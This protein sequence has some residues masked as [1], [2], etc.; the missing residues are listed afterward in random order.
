MEKKYSVPAF[1]N[2]VDATKAKTIMDFLKTTFSIFNIRNAV[3]VVC[4]IK[5][6]V[7]MLGKSVFHL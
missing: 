4:R 1:F 7:T 2:L 3:F 6:I 5:N